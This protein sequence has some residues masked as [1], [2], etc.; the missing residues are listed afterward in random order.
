MSQTLTNFFSFVLMAAQPPLINARSAFILKG[1][2]QVAVYF[3]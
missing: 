1:Y 2:A 3:G